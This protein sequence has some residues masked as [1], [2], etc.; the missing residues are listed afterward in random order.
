MGDSNSASTQ[1]APATAPVMILVAGI[2]S[3]IS[4]HRK[5]NP[6]RISHPC[7]LNDNEIQIWATS[8]KT[9]DYN[10]AIIPFHGILNQKISTPAITKSPLTEQHTHPFGM[11][12]HS[13]RSFSPWPIT[14]TYRKIP[15]EFL[16]IKL[17]RKLILPY[18]LNPNWLAEF[19]LYHCDFLF[20]LL[21]E[22]VSQKSGFAAPEKAGEDHH[23][24]AA[25]PAAHLCHS[26]SFERSRFRLVVG[27][28]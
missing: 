3:N 27:K 13:I 26:E 2:V 18:L 24:H 15:S 14:I 8:N 23:R 11:S 25:L 21:R 12:I 20:A 16:S 28:K 7:G 19:I 10:E 6:T 22:K 1:N 4:H 5:H 9:L 17:F